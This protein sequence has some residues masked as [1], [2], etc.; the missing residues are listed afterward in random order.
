MRQFLAS[1]S[2]LVAACAGPTVATRPVAPTPVQSAAA[3]ETTRNTPERG[4][5]TDPLAA[6][7]EPPADCARYSQA[8]N[9][10]A[11]ACSGEALARLDRAM[12]EQDPVKRDPT[13]AEL[14]LCAEFDP[15]LVAALRAEL[16]PTECGDR[17]VAESARAERLTPAIRDTLV[18]LS[19]AAKLAR[20]VRKP[21]EL[22]PPHTKARVQDFIRGAM[23]DWVTAEARAIGELG[24]RGARLTGYGKGIVA[25]EAG[26]ADMRFVEVFRQ[27]PLPEELGSDPELRDAYYSSLDQGL[28]PRKDRGRDAALVGLKMLADIGVIR[29]R[30]VDQARALLSKLYNGRRVDALDGLLLPALPVVQ[31]K[32]L[33]QRLAA[34]LPTF[35]A[36]YLLRS[37]NPS[38]PALLGALLGRGLPTSL[39]D[40]LD[41][42]ELAPEARLL[43]AR[44]L[45]ELG[46][47]YW[48]AADFG[49]A[50]AA[51]L[52]RGEPG[53]DAKL[54]RALGLA[55][56]QGPKDAAQ[57]MLR[58]PLPQGV[59]NVS[60]LDA[61]GRARGE[62]AGMAAYDAAYIRELV[63]PTQKDP[64]FFR[65]LA[66]RYQR[67]LGLLKAP[68]QQKLARDR[69]EAAASTAKAVR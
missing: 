1:C 63:P 61:L 52:G 6:V 2:L 9:K 53:S 3:P 58:G 57:M 5:A 22:A 51:A 42:S 32:T 47:T 12:G 14:E 59:G 28:D 46:R 24:R 55:L 13:L 25:V 65:D 39:R 26:M 54:L 35:Y 17:L 43:W 8:S 27:V 36:D 62:A 44:G 15:G 31:P 10:P 16:A 68:A 29:E 37:A 34:T 4:S 45:F 67:A 11:H 21:P 19:L 7:P 69:A 30:R 41:R 60:E 18:G 64:A 40:K 38:D 33:E 48:R 50:R 56:E 20:L 49:R 23:A 66:T